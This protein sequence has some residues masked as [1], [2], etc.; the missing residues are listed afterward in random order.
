MG[1]AA[2]WVGGT[3]AAAVTGPHYLLAVPPPCPLAGQAYLPA[4][5]PAALLAGGGGA[6]DPAR[7]PPA[8]CPQHRAGVGEG[9]AAGGTEPTALGALL[10]LTLRTVAGGAHA[11]R[12]CSQHCH[13]PH[14]CRTQSL[15]ARRVMA[16]AL[17]RQWFGVFMRPA[18]PADTW[19]VEGE[20]AGALRGKARR[21]GADVWFCCFCSLF[22]FLRH[23]RKPTLAAR[24]ACAGLAGWLEE[25]YIKKYM[26]NNELQYRWGRG[27]AGRGAAKGQPG[28]AAHAPHHAGA[29]IGAKQ[30]AA[31]PLPLPERAGV[32]VSAAP[33]LPPTTAT[34][35]RWR[36]GAPALR[37]P[38][39]SSTAPPR[40]TPLSCARSRC[41][42]VGTGLW[43]G[44]QL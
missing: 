2:G 18:T 39:A 43:A 20:R 22:L 19:L 40:S 15:E 30:R 4:A 26:G 25:Q 5:A 29:A 3:G 36:G 38:G 6:P 44:A 7:P 14:R 21:W 9:Q 10:G 33:L 32:G 34:R 17:A 16:R 41:M 24:S 12:T 13:C 23:D 28:H 27:G 11:G 31:L 8:G 37:R 42:G 1:L 35:R